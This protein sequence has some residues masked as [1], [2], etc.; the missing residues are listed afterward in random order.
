MLEVTILMPALNEAETIGACVDKAREFLKRHDISGEVLIADN[1]ST[2]G[3]QQIARDKGA[4]VIDAPTKGY[5]AALLAGIEAAEGRFIIMGD[6]DNSYDFSNLMPFVEKL[7]GGADLVMGNRFR[8]GIAKNAM[9]PLHRYLGNPVLS[10]T[11]R[12]FYRTPVGDFHCGLRGFSRQAIRALNLRS[13]GMEFASEMIV[14]ATLF[15][16]TIVEVPTTLEPDGRTRPPHLRSWRDGWRH[17]KLLLSY[18]PHWLFLYPGLILLGVGSAVFL[19]LVAGPVTIAGVRFDNAA[20]ILAAALILTGAQMALFY[21]LARLHA[22][23]HNGL[24]ASNMFRNFRAA[25]SVDKACILGLLLIILGVSSAAFAVL[26][27]I[28]QGFGDL[29]PGLITRPATVAVVGVSLGIQ[30]IT[31]GFL[32]G[33]IDDGQRE[34]E[35]NGA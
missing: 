23:R 24:P 14:K 25:V 32:W 10:L 35:S 18:A 7:R 11:G 34:T 1:G 26:Y 19:A 4:R 28:G 29:D 17:L 9:P 12:I 3:S 22:V 8:G 6:S 31:S 13:P 27:W 21:A 5:G 15:G 16:L 2:D 33:I 20:F 30:L